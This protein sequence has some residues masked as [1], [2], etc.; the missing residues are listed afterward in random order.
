MLLL[1]LILSKQL[2]HIRHLLCVA[3]QLPQDHLV[4]ILVAIHVL[5]NVESAVR[6]MPRILD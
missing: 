5:L 6:V 4:L 2:L 1:L 3:E